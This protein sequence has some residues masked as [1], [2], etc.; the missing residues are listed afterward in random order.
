MRILFA[1][2]AHCAN[3]A[4]ALKRA[5]ARVRVIKLAESQNAVGRMMGYR[6]WQELASA[7]SPANQVSP[8]DDEVTADERA[9]RRTHQ[10]QSLVSALQVDNATASSIVDQLRPTGKRK[11]EKSKAAQDWRTLFEEMVARGGIP[12]VRNT[13]DLEDEDDY[14]VRVDEIGDGD[15]IQSHPH[16]L[17]PGS[18]FSI[19]QIQFVRKREG[20]RRTAASL[21]QCP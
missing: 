15:I 11:G 9:S 3:L 17:E 10:L 6:N 18:P 7:C 14:K 16:F 2:T 13:D 1:T 12:G 8:W 4:K 19:R 21:L 5:M 20:Y